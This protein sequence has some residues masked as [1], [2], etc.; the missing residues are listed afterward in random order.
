LGCVVS[1]LLYQLYNKG[2]ATVLQTAGWLQTRLQTV[3]FTRENSRF[4]KKE[5]TVLQLVDSRLYKRGVTVL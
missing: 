5:A 2:E 3:G 4:Y 1:E